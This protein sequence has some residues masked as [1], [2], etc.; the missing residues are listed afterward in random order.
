MAALVVGLRE[1][2]VALR[3]VVSVASLLSLFSW[4]LLVYHLNQSMLEHRLV[5]ELLL[6][7]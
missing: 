7:V 3:S 4:H 1:E 2:E 6:V 5:E